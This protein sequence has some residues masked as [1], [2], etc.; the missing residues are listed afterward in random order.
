MSPIWTDQKVDEFRSRL[1]QSDLEKFDRRYQEERE[2]LNT[3]EIRAELID[4]YQQ[5]EDHLDLVRAIASAFH[6]DPLA[7]GYESGYKFAFTE[8]LEELN[9]LGKQEGARNGDVLLVKEN[10]REVYLCVVECKAG[11]NAGGTWVNELKDIQETVEERS[12]NIERLKSQMGVEDKDVK[13][14]QYVLLG[15]IIQIHSMD[16]DRLS[17]EMNIPQEFTFWGCDM[18]NFSI[19]NVHGEINDAELASVVEDSIDALKIENPINYTYSDHPLTQLKEVIGALINEKREKSDSNP[20][21]FNESEFVDEFVSGLQMGVGGQ[22]RE[23]LIETRVKTLLDIGLKIGILV[24][25]QS[26]MNTDRD[27]RV[28]FQGEKSHVAQ[29]ATEEK[30]FDAL[31]EEKTKERAFKEVREEFELL[32]EQTHLS[33]EDWFT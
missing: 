17:N 7:D 29:T 26:K 28:Y 18:R 32:P 14:I 24:K 9:T 13:H 31:A 3:E 25:S 20:L 5:T 4:S 21:E 1:P 22:E 12:G 27:Y 19:V 16:F 8:P 10:E 23:N 6:Q 33:D 30:Y 11:R 15:K 2:D